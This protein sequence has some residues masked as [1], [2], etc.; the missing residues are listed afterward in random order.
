MDAEIVDEDDSEHRGNQRLL[1]PNE[2]ANVAADFQRGRPV[3]QT[4]HTPENSVRPCLE[5]DDAA[6]ASSEAP[7]TT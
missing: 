4:A 2:D 5:P 6:Q 3:D 1:V 7:P